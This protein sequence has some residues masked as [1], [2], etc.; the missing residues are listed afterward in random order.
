[1][2]GGRS[3]SWEVVPPGV[4][5]RIKGLWVLRGWSSRIRAKE[6]GVVRWAKRMVA[7]EGGLWPV[8]VGHMKQK[9]GDLPPH[10]K[11]KGCKE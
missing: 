7:N 10:R 5:I 2:G 8:S 1:V 3:S 9:G 11:R 6:P 4:E